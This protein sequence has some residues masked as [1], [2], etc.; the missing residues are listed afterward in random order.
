[1]WM[2]KSY[3]RLSK[4]VIGL[5]AIASLLLA[6]GCGSQQAARPPQ[7]VAVKA[8][9]VQQKDTP[10]SYEYIGQVEAKDQVDIRANVTGRILEKMVQGGAMVHKG[11][12]LFR[13]DSRQYETNLLNSQAQLAQSQATLSNSRRDT[14]RYRTLIEQNAV[15]QQVYDN[16]VA[17][18][19]QNEALVEANSAKVQQSQNDL[20]D[21]I[22]VSPIDG[23]IDLTDLSVGNF[24]TAGSTSLGTISSSGP[25]KVVFKMSENE[26]LRFAQQGKSDTASS[27]AQQLR[28][29]LSDGT[30]YPYMGRV[31]QIDRALTQ[32]TGTLSIKATFDNPQG[33]LV[34]GMFA[35]ILSTG[36]T[37]QGAILIPKRAIQQILGKNFVT[38]VVDGDKA[39]NRPVTLGPVVGNFQIVDSGL[40]AQ[41]I[42]VV[43][44]A[45]K[46]QPGATLNIEMV[47]PDAFNAP[48]A[49]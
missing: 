11:Q 32:Q 47:A 45:N 15:A 23:K 29:V 6:T 18:E 41:D 44:G 35:R 9:Q 21:T 33:L 37:R 14:A 28:L 27:W 43:E 2:G 39:E 12:P 16:A 7:A 5:A 13:I 20:N 42:V 31:D 49:K 17:A 10:I 1:M 4:Q 38:V 40:N 48:D 30:A 26:Y 19:Q 8:M 22:V 25:V 24:V 3:G 46:T 34:P 36:E